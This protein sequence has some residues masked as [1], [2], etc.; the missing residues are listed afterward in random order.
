MIQYRIICDTH[1]TAFVNKVNEAINFGWKLQ[2]GMA[3]SC[4]G[5]GKEWY[6]Q[7]LTFE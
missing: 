5:S 6:Y 2:G 1:L 3:V 7:A 4:S